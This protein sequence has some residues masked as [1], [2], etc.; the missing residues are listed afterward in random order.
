MKTPTLRSTPSLFLFE[1]IFF[2][3]GGGTLHI[4]TVGNGLQV[5]KEAFLFGKM[6]TLNEVL[7]TTQHGGHFPDETMHGPSNF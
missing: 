4:F 1:L 2:F 5:K 3:G 7:H 6:W